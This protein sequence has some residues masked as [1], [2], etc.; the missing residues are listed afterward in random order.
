MQ[1]L[2][3]VDWSTRLTELFNTA[4]LSGLSSF[5]IELCAHTLDDFFC[6]FIILCLVV[7]ISFR[8]ISLSLA[9]G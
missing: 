9:V 7:L 2:I 4:T 8:P 3:A 1:Y 6:S 5:P